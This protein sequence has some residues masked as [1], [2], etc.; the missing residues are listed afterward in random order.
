[1]IS[2]HETEMLDQPVTEAGQETNEITQEESEEPNQ[3]EREKS[4]QFSPDNLLTLKGYLNDNEINQQI[5][6]QKMLSEQDTS[7]ASKSDDYSMNNYARQ[8][9]EFHEQSASLKACTC[10]PPLEISS[11]DVP[12]RLHCNED[13]MEIKNMLLK[14]H[15][16]LEKLPQNVT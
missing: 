2:T 13:S 7:Q 16:Y 15:K 1:M 9:S 4:Q 6:N 12:R 3:S 14:V 10:E 5:S 8:P 11:D